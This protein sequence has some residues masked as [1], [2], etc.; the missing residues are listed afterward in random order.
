MHMISF[1]VASFPKV[2]ESLYTSISNGNPGCYAAL[3]TFDLICLFHLCHSD[4]CVIVSHCVINLHFYDE[5]CNWA[6]FHVLIGKFFFEVHV[7]TFPPLLDWIVCFY[8]LICRKFF[9]KYI[10]LI[11]YREEGRE[12]ESQ[13]RWWVR[14]INQSPPA[15]PPLGMCPQPRH[16]PLTGI[17]PGTLQSTGWDAL[18]SEPNQFWRS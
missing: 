4:W 2:S 14:I 13:K 1:N 16:M 5:S 6:F 9:I 18:S 7:Q 8:L 17:E 3:P 11:F 15:H 10:L 12:I